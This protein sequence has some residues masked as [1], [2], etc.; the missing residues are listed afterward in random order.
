MF[1]LS[2]SGIYSEHP[3]VLVV[4]GLSQDRLKTDMAHAHTRGSLA[5]LEGQKEN[6]MIQVQ[7][8]FLRLVIYISQA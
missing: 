3:V 2:V 4:G 7:V 6:N 8:L 1:W 5:L